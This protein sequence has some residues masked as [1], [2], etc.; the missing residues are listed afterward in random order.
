[1]YEFSPNRRSSR[2]LAFSIDNKIWNNMVKKIRISPLTSYIYSEWP[3]RQQFIAIWYFVCYRTSNFV[4]TLSKIQLFSCRHLQFESKKWT[5]QLEMVHEIYMAL[6]LLTSLE[7]WPKSWTIISL[8]IGSRWTIEL[9][10]RSCD[11]L[12]P[13]DFFLV[14]YLKHNSYKRNPSTPEQVKE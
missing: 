5:W 6:L 7:R 8:I 11:F 9:V 14:G 2:N 3:R 4:E 13:S 1:M 12:I 10:H